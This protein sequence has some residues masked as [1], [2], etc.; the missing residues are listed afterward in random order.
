MVNASGKNSD[1]LPYLVRAVGNKYFILAKSGTVH[2]NARF[3]FMPYQLFGCIY[4]KE[5]LTLLLG[6]YYFR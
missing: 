6:W 2:K 3:I 5:T 1:T 4:L